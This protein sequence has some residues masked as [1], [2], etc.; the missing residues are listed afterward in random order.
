MTHT[1]NDNNIINS[2]ISN[3]ATQ[4][5][6]ML[7]THCALAYGI[8]STLVII[9]FDQLQVAYVYILINHFLPRTSMMILDQISFLLGR[10]VESWGEML[11][12]E[13]DFVRPNQLE[14]NL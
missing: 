3:R 7:W 11:I 10:L 12:K 4:M 14:I 5:I 6:Y 1:N 8:M 13:V 2:N 9:V